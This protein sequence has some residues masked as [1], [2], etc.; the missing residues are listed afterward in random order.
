MAF[1]V[2]SI[3]IL[4]F[5]LL[6]GLRGEGYSVN[7]FLQTQKARMVGHLIEKE[8][9]EAASKYI[10]F[11]YGDTEKVRENW[12]VSMKSLGEKYRIESIEI[13]PIILD[14]YF[15]MGKYY[16]TI[17]DYESQVNHIYEGVVTCQNGGITFASVNIPCG[18]VDA[19]RDTIGYELNNIFVTY[20][21]G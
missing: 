19:R 12:I 1:G 7:C 3:A 15:P 17:Y 21:P 10:G 18:S 9:Y 2:I 8:Q 6:S 4:L 13:E 16:I 5:M 14:D 11:S 20:N